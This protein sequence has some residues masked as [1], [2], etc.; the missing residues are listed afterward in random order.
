MATAALQGQ[1]GE[2]HYRGAVLHPGVLKTAPAPLSFH[3]L[4]PS[5]PQPDPHVSLTPQPEWTGPSLLDA[6][7]AERDGKKPTSL[8]H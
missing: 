5:H 4:C 2:G 8:H 7:E 6:G 3:E 1:G